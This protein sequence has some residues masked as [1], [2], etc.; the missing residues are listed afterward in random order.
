MKR[1]IVDVEAVMTASGHLQPKVIHT[2]GG[3][4]IIIEKVLGKPVIRGF[5]DLG[6]QGICFTCEAH[7]HT[8]YLVFDQN[9]V[10][11]DD[12]FYVGQWVMGV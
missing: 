8:I 12:R 11:D 1:M 10:P 5:R 3:K 7:N 4:E 6:A 9:C 2:Q